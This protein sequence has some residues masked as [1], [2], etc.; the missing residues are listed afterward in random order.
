MSMSDETWP[1]YALQT[2]QKHWTRPDK[3][4][5]LS[6]FERIKTLSAAAVFFRGRRG[7]FTHFSSVM[8]SLW[9]VY[10]R[11]RRRARSL[12]SELKFKKG[13]KGYFELLSHHK[14]HRYKPH[15][16]PGTVRC[17]HS[18]YETDTCSLIPVI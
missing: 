12:A 8:I 5:A 4:D 14:T 16:S 13:G 11:A 7:C 9:P 6:L 18:H 2:K 1:W 15:M 10:C 3:P 17:S